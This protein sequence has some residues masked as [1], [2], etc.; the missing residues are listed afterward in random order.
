[1]NFLQPISQT[2]FGGLKSLYQ[3]DVAANQIQLNPTKKEFKGDYTIAVFPYSKEAGK[4]PT[5]VGQA[6]RFPHESYL[7]V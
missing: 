2:V 6:H 3:L 1:M 7:L 4:S 5:E